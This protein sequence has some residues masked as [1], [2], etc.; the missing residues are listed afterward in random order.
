MGIHLGGYFPPADIANDKKAL[1]RVNV[2]HCV[3]A[4]VPLWFMLQFARFQQHVVAAA[5]AHLDAAKRAE[6]HG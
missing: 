3:E 2:L 4:D 5:L 1:L 6:L